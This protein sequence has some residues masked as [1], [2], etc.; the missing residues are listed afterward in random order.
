MKNNIILLLV[1][2]MSCSAAKSTKALTTKHETQSEIRNSL[3]KLSDTIIDTVPLPYHTILDYPTSFESGAIISRTIDGLGYRYYWATKDLR[4]EDL[5]YTISSDSRPAKETLDHLYGLTMLIKNASTNSPNI[6][7]QPE[8]EMT[9]DEQR[10]ATLMAIK[11][12]S[13]AFRKMDKNQVSEM[14]IIF[15]RGEN[16][17]EYPIWNLLNGPL[18]DAIYHVGQIVSYRRA[19]G[20]P[21]DPR[22]NVFMG[23]NRE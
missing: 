18:A 12:A 14:N 2:L 10:S 16:K 9:W 20:N 8:N 13:D 7:P 5:D 1:C 22:V 4:P 17:S 6:R 19:S 11:S 23:R 21:L 15:Q 3:L